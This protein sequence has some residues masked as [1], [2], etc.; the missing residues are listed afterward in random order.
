M[1]RLAP[2]VLATA[3]GVVGCGSSSPGSGST[4]CTTNVCIKSFSFKPSSLTVPVGTAVTWTQQ[5]STVHNVTGTGTSTFKSGNL[6][7]GQ[8]FTFTFSTAGTFTYMC[9]IHPN[10][11]GTVIVQ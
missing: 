7:K 5:D 8:T 10:M 6:T 9:T 4:A 3:L 2:I 1:K 11:R